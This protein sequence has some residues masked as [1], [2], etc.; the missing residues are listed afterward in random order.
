MV[1]KYIE[2][3]MQVDTLICIRTCTMYL[4]NNA[5]IHTERSAPW[6]STPWNLSSALN[7]V[8][9]IAFMTSF[10]VRAVVFS[11]GRSTWVSSKLEIP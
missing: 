8:E 7:S 9:T 11:S 2:C 6:R 3:N 5:I 1:H 4:P 10:L